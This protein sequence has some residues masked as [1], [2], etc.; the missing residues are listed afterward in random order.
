MGDL[1]QWRW[2]QRGTSREKKMH[3]DEFFSQLQLPAAVSQRVLN[4]HSAALLIK[5]RLVR[6]ALKWESVGAR[7]SDTYCKMYK[8]NTCGKCIRILSGKVFWKTTWQQKQRLHFIDRCFQ[9]IFSLYL[10][11]KHLLAETWQCF[12]SCL[13]HTL[14]NDCRVSQSVNRPA[15]GAKA[16]FNLKEGGENNSQQNHFLI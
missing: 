1:F 7:L 9:Y 12:P 14:Q 16:H 11:K 10:K 6:H 5:T 3:V 13:T 2:A 4:M 15:C 8:Y